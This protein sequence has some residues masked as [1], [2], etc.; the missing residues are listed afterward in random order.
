LRDCEIEALSAYHGEIDE[1]ARK[2]ALSEHQKIF[3]EIVMDQ[4]HLQG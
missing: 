3:D 2:K 4:Q 1:A